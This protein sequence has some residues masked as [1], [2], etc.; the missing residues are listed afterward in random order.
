V[1]ED[2]SEVEQIHV[3]LQDEIGETIHRQGAGV[4]LTEERMTVNRSP[5]S[6]SATS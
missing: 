1:T 6:L 3:I 2:L 5:N 4:Q